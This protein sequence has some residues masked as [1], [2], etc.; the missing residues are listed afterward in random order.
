LPPTFDCNAHLLTSI[1]IAGNGQ[2]LVESRGPWGC[3]ATWLL[4]HLQT[5]LMLGIGNA[6]AANGNLRNYF[7]LN[8]HR[9]R[10]RTHPFREHNRCLPSS[11][12]CLHSSCISMSSSSVKSVWAVVGSGVLGVLRALGTMGSL[13]SRVLEKPNG[14]K[15]KCV[16]WNWEIPSNSQP[17][18]A[19]EMSYNVRY[20]FYSNKKFKV[21]WG[22]S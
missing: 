11:N 12:S 1:S 8:G 10:R 19:F 17:F 16:N 4:T 2:Q 20:F 3:R 9:R 21:I 22:R 6:A 14:T 7:K 15:P 5:A 18:I 13:G